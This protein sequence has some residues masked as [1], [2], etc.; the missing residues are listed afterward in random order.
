MPPY[1]CRHSCGSREDAPCDN[2]P[3]PPPPREA[4]KK[5]EEEQ[6]EEME[7]ISLG[8]KKKKKNRRILRTVAWKQR[9]LMT[10]T[11]GR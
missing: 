6:D 1:H 5:A 11:E 4:T 9:T 10:A 7:E 8:R 2:F 3:D